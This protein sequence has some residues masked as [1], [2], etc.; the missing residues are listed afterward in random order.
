MVAVDGPAAEGRALVAPSS[1]AAAAATAAAAKAR[2]EQ[3]VDFFCAAYSLAERRRVLLPLQRAEAALAA[4]PPERAPLS[5]EADILPKLEVRKSRCGFCVPYGWLLK[6]FLHGCF[7]HTWAV[8]TLCST[9]CWLGPTTPWV[10][11]RLAAAA[12]GAES[13]AG[14]EGLCPAPRGAGA[15]A[16]H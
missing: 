8:E 14:L 9:L 5:L 11:T 10:P 12:G 16:C 4:V 7:C 3:I 15:P 6:F 1:S 2:T 13:W